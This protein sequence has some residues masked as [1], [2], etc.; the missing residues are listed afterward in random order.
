MYSHCCDA[1]I[2]KD[3]HTGDC[4]CTECGIVLEDRPLTY[5]WHDGEDVYNELD[6]YEKKFESV[7]ENIH[8]PTFWLSECKDIFGTIS[9]KMKV[10]IHGIYAIVC[11]VSKECDKY[12]EII[13]ACYDISAAKIRKMISRIVGLR[14]QKNINVDVFFQIGYNLALKFQDINELITIFQK[15]LQTIN[16]T[17]IAISCALYCLYYNFDVQHTAHVNNINKETIK[18]AIT[19]VKILL[20]EQD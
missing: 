15:C 5:Q 8:A 10:G 20:K 9:E 4:V 3:T 13:S 14:L 12:S 16:Q 19:K 17:P 11:I 7:L 2:F 1:E 18:K 6:G